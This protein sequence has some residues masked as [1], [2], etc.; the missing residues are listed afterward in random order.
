VA[1]HKNQGKRADDRVVW[2]R[3]HD[4]APVLTDM[5]ALLAWIAANAIDEYRQISP[6]AYLFCRPSDGHFAYHGSLRAVLET[7]GIRRDPVSGIYQTMYS[8]RH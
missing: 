7:F 1:I 6:M 4:V 5:R 8:C 2:S 3:D